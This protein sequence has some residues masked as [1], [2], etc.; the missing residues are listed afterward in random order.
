M[1]PCSR[2]KIGKMGKTQDAYG[3]HFRCYQCSHIKDITIMSDADYESYQRGYS[4]MNADTIVH[5]A[6]AKYMWS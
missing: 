3:L 6:K 5:L 4:S 1:I 2:C